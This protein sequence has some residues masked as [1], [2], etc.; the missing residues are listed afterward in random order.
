MCPQCPRRHHLFRIT[1]PMK[2][3]GSFPEEWH[4]IL[5]GLKWCD[6]V[7][8]ASREQWRGLLSDA[9][10]F[11]TRWGSAAHLLWWTSR[12][13]FGIHPIAPAARLNEMGLIPAL[14]GAVVVA[15]TSQTAMFR[16]VSS[17]LQTYHRYRGGV[18][19]ADG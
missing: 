12:D 4:A 15:L 19:C 11:L 10:N 1:Q 5:A 9:E 17:G 3:G 14:R 16:R 7:D 6:L 8:W 18:A 13:L 2:A